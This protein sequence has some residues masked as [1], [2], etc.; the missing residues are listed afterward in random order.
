MIEKEIGEFINKVELIELI[1]YITFND[2]NEQLVKL[3]TQ[4]YN[5]M[6]EGFDDD[7]IP[8][9]EGDFGKCNTNPIPT[10]GIVSNDSYLEQIKTIKGDTIKWQRIKSE[11]SKIEQ[12]KGPIDI[13]EIT[14]EDGQKIEEFYLSPYNKKTS[15]KAPAGFIIEKGYTANSDED[16]QKKVNLAW[17]YK[18]N[19]KLLE[20]LGIYN[21]IY[22]FICKEAAD[23][24]RTNNVVD[25]G[26]T[27]KILPSYFSE[28][29]KYLKQG[30]FAYLIANNMGTIF[31]ELGD[32]ENA[33]KMFEESIRLTPNNI[34]Y[35]DPKIGLE[36]LKN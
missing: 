10:K 22:S 24:V 35:S 13:Y 7:E 19:G 1:T 34:E 23:H 33:K 30:S 32:K 8:F 11:E 29:D 12:I 6:D 27:R 14:T 16:L 36:E 31:A 21:Q 28:A 9:A 2:V 26:N 17:Q 15:N 18:K 4:G 5:F 20:G 25:E 3:T